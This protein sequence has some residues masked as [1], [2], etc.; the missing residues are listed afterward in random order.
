MPEQFAAL[1]DIPEKTSRADA[2]NDAFTFFD[3]MSSIPQDSTPLQHKSA[4]CPTWDAAQVIK[5]TVSAH[6]QILNALISRSAQL[7]AELWVEHGALTAKM[8]RTETEL[9][10]AYL[11]QEGV[12]DAAN[13][14]AQIAQTRLDALL[15][16]SKQRDDAEKNASLT[17]EGYLADVARESTIRNRAIEA[18]QQV[19]VEITAECKRGHWLATCAQVAVSIRAAHIVERARQARVLVKLQTCLH[20]ACEEH[21]RAILAHE[22]SQDASVSDSLAA[23]Q[24]KLVSLREQLCKEGYRRRL[25]QE[26]ELEFFRLEMR[27]LSWDLE[28]KLE[29]SALL[30]AVAT[31]RL[32]CDNV[33]TVSE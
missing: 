15:R 28:A 2:P 24:L 8:G 16:G 18:W 4:S 23:A 32:E 17:L 30:S 29:R 19:N 20:I 11:R 6:D 25:L 31:A 22:I 9:N 26:R 21:R 5:E 7:S 10:Q 1:V 13:R 33:T 3:F 14:Q 27:R 12:L